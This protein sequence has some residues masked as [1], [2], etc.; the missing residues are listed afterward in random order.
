MATYHGHSVK[1]FPDE[2]AAAVIV[3][4]IT[5]M[6]LPMNPEHVAEIVGHRA[7]PAHVAV[8]SIRPTMGFTTYA[9][10]AVLG[11]I[12]AAGVSVDSDTDPGIVMYQTLLDA[13]GAPTAG[14]VHRSWT[15]KKGF[16]CPMRIRCDHRG[17][18]TIEVMAYPIKKSSN[19]TIVESD[20]A[21][22]PTVTV[23]SAR[24]TLGP[25]TLGGVTFADYTGLD[26]DFG[27]QID[28]V[29]V[30]SNVEDTYIGVRNNAPKVTIRGV[31]P[32][33]L[34]ATQIPYGGLALTHANSAIY[35]RKRKQD[36]T[37]FNAAGVA[38]H[39]KITLAG[40]TNVAGAATWTASRIN[41]NDILCTLAEDS[42]GTA[43]LVITTAQT[44][45]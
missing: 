21:A 37:W 34:K 44:H 45:P 18:A 23:A 5:Q 35:L 25:I 2:L 9:L 32:T 17:D 41:E 36:G 11:A 16:I 12:G 4:D 39:I 7:R 14:A 24:W 19:Q 31:D 30:E 6:D 20:T 3:P 29:G 40:L 33:W 13:Y 22:L 38:V 42:G 27:Y 15:M 26:V 10:E 8:N 43:P 1:I 28:P